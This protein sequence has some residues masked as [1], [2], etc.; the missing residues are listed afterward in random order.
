MRGNK[1]E[2]GGLEVGENLEGHVIKVLG[3]KMKR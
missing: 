2:V 1:E 3:E